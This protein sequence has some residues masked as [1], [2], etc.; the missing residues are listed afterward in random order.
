VANWTDVFRRFRWPPRELGLATTANLALLAT[1]QR[2]R[3]ARTC[4]LA[5][6]LGL[7]TMLMMG[8]LDHFVFAGAS[9]ERIRTLSRFSLAQR[10]GIVLFSAV[11][12]EVVYRLI[13]ATAIASALQAALRKATSQ[14]AMMAM[15]LS[16]I[17]AA[18]LF[19]LAHAGNLQNVPHPYLRAVTLNGVAGIVLG[20]LYWFR[21]L[22]A[23]VLAHLTADAFI[24][25]IVANF[26]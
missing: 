2:Q 11:T 24:Y 19:G 18:L 5:I 6:A 8:T 16:I 21:G 14:S 15:W 26:I 13:I 12:E 7:L 10:T 20:Y 22:E 9:L 17:A 23:A 4:L 1:D 25:L 3:F